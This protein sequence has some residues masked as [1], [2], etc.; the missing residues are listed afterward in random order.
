MS[1]HNLPFNIVKTL[2]DNLRKRLFLQNLK[3]FLFFIQEFGLHTL[4][5]HF[6]TQVAL[7]NK[8]ITTCD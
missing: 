3:K 5:E 4:L 8:L 2:K 1:N 7:F 6:E